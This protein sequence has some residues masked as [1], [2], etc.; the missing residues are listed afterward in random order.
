MKVKVN[1]YCIFLFILIFLELDCF[2]LID[3][4][5]T[6]IFGLNYIDW[7]VVIRLT[8]VIFTILSVQTKITKKLLLKFLPIGVIILTITSAVAGN[9]SYG[10]SFLNGIIAQREW[11]SCSLMFYPIFIWLKNK[12]FTIRQ[13]I[14][15]LLVISMLYISVCVL[16]YFLIN[17]IVFLHTS[18]NQRYGGTRLRFSSFYPAIVVGFIIDGLF[19]KNYRI[20]TFKNIFVLVGYLFLLAV[21]TKGRMVT[22]AAI[23][24][25]GICM[26]L[27]RSSV[28][29]KTFA[30]IVLLATIVFLANSQIGRDAL[31]VVFGSGTGTSADT[32]SIRN[33]EQ[34]Y[35]IK[36]V[37]QNPITVVLGCGYPSTD[38]IAQS[39]SSPTIGYWTYYTTDVGI[40]GN[41]F[42]YGLLGIIWFAILY[43]ALLIKGYKI[44]K[45][46][47]RTCYL[48][49]F[50]GDVLGCVSL[51]PLCYNFT[52]AFPI[53]FAMLE[54]EYEKIRMKE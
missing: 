23:G 45:K 44:Y 19:D 31:D 25:I 33:L 52:I 29:Q 49:F 17:K 53:F 1:R 12:K 37:T 38:A 22:L 43:I 48:E 39:I 50:I 32:I 9:I 14:E 54:F 26:L 7:L 6:Y 28:T 15:M 30:I 24:G 51:W 5:T 4:Y 34:A 3:R 36:K 16:Q 27:R 21:I 18:V 13:L 11:L 10:Q 40:V 42:C 46:S 35:Y 2:Y 41:F 8:T 47:V 20:D